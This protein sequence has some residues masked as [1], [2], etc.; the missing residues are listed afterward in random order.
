MTIAEINTKLIGF[1]E[2]EHC[3]KFSEIN[4]QKII[5][6]KFIGQEYNFNITK[7]YNIY[8]SVKNIKIS[9]KTTNFQIENKI[10]QK[11]KIDWYQLPFFNIIKQ[12]VFEKITKK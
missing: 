5:T 1:G 11:F 10:L 7:I 2:N 12:I 4:N 6:I 3:F 9:N 8:K